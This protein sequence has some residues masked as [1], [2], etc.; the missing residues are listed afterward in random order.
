MYCYRRR[1]AAWT[2]LLLASCLTLIV[3][4]AV[5]LLTIGVCGWRQVI[6][7]LVLDNNGAAACR[8]LTR[9]C[10]FQLSAI[11]TAS[12]KHGVQVIGDGVSPG[13]EY[14]FFCQPSPENGRT[15]IYRS[16]SVNYQLPRGESAYRPQ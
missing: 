14:Q 12:G 6:A 1:G 9:D 5:Q 16:V 15:T 3:G 2:I 4:A 11:N 7:T 10:N 13:R 8:A